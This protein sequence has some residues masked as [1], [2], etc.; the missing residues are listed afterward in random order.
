MKDDRK[1]RTRTRALPVLAVFVTLLGLLTG[2]R[3]LLPLNTDE[4]LLLNNREH[5][6][7]IRFTEKT[8]ALMLGVVPGGHGLSPNQ[9][10]DVAEFAARFKTEFYEP[11]PHFY[12]SVPSRS[13]GGGALGSWRSV[14]LA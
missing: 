10:V 4:A 3:E 8:E 11:H 9:E 2:C 14:R 6:H 13:L 7:E 12:S 5:R 1:A